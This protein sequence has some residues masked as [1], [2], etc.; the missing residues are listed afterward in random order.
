MQK[1]GEVTHGKESPKQQIRFISLFFEQT[2][3]R[4][5]ARSAAW[6]WSIKES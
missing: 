4:A 5:Y 1:R 3:D 6:F 2:I